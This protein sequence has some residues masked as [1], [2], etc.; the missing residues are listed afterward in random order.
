[1]PQLGQAQTGSLR[2]TPKQL[3]ISA[4]DKSAVVFKNMGNNHNVPFIWSAIATVATGQTTVVIA[5]EVKFYDMELASYANVTVTALSDPGANYWVDYNTGTNVI[6]LTLDT[7]ASSDIDF[8]VQF[9]LGPAINVSELS[10][11]GTGAP[12]QSYP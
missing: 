11:R 8:N 1:M 10:T 4:S 7:A 12:A 9:I 6:T 5:D 3:K 2:S